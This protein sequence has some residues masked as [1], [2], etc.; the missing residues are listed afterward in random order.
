MKRSR[1]LGV[2]DDMLPGGHSELCCEELRARAVYAKRSDAPALP[3][4]YWADIP[5]VRGFELRV[6]PDDSSASRFRSPER[7]C[8][9]RIRAW[10]DSSR[11]NADRWKVR[12]WIWAIAD[13]HG[14]VQDFDWKQ[15]RQE[16]A[17]RPRTES[18]AR[19]PAAS[20][21]RTVDDL[22]DVGALETAPTGEAA[23]ADGA[24]AGGSPEGDDDRRHKK[25]KKKKKAEGDE[26]GAAAGGTRRSPTP[27]TPPEEAG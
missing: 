25:K 12:K 26:E 24:A 5:E 23:G 15:Q 27:G 3:P 8:H 14:K 13:S 9:L 17:K 21:R 1:G 19:A 20:S 7:V 22:M 6:V 10:W 4:C 2:N 18:P 16:S 11:G